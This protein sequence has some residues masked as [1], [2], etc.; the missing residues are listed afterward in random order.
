MN[1]RVATPADADAIAAIYAPVVQ[2]TTISF[3]LAPPTADEMRDRIVKTLRSLPWLVSE[4]AARRVDGYVYAGRH[5]ERPASQWSVDVT[6]YVRKD[7][8]GQGVGSRLYATLFKELAPAPDCGQARPA[9]CRGGTPRRRP[10]NRG[11]A[12]LSRRPRGGRARGRRVPTAAKT[13][14]ATGRQ[15]AR[16]SRSEVS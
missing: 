14:P 11:T 2:D 1:I 6:A 7:A 3:E 8:Q 12:V 13:S 15:F 4:D 5:R 10:E 9:P 16:R